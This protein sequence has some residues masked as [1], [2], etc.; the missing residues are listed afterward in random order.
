M[1][2]RG[3]V[4]RGG[5]V[6]LNNVLLLAKA[7]NDASMMA[8]R[9]YAGLRRSILGAG[10]GVL[11]MMIDSL[12]GRNSRGPPPNCS[13]YVSSKIINNEKKIQKHPRSEK[14]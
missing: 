10:G 3:V 4:G 1:V 7:S 13:N 5:Y 11:L 6:L 14:Q 2:P 9:S 12:I 8:G